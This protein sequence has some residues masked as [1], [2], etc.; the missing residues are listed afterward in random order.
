MTYE[1]IDQ[2]RDAN[3]AL[4][5]HFF[6]RDTLRFF[7]SRIGETVYGGR[8]FV[9]SEKPPFGPR[10]W[11]LRV[12]LDSGAVETVGE[13]CAMPRSRAHAL[14]VRAAAAHDS[15]HELASEPQR[16]LLHAAAVFEWAPERLEAYAFGILYG[17]YRADD[18][19]RPDRLL[20]EE[21]AS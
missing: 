11:T 9:T 6:D 5:H 7:G 18:G 17:M 12:A 4:G 21:A 3:R 20:R 14:A 8:Y 1:T 16:R 13:H 2:I 15:V 19:T 10:R